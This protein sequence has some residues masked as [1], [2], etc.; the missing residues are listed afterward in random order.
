MAVV[1]NQNLAK[2]R[3]EILADLIDEM[4]G[5]VPDVYTGEEGNLMLLFQ[6][7]AGV[8]EAVNLAIQ[9]LSE[10]QFVYTANPVALERH[11][12]ERDIPLKV[13]TVSTGNLRISGAGGTY[14][15]LDSEAAYDPQTGDDLLYFRTTATGTIPN[16]GSPSA[17]TLADLVTAGNLTG[18]FEYVI[19]FL[20][21]EGET[22]MGAE[23]APLTVAASKIRLTNIPIGGAG[24]TKRRIYRQKNGSNLYQLVATINDNVLT[25]Y[26][27]NIADG[28]LGGQPPAISTAEAITLPVESV[29]AGD[30][31]NV[32]ANSITEVI[33]MPNGV[34]DTINLAAM[35]GGSDPED[36]EDFRAR[37]L[38][39]IQ[40]PNTGAPGDLKTWSE[41]ITGVETA[42]VFSND[43]FGT[44]TNGHTTVRIAGPNGAIPDISVQNAVAAALALK[45][46]ANIT[47]HVGTFTAVPTAVTVTI[48]VASGFVLADISAG[49]TQAITDYINSLQVGETIRVNGIIDAV[50]GLAGVADVAVS[51]PAT[52]LA[53]GATS[54]RTPGAITVS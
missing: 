4:Q 48:T 6:V 36:S 2:S 27:D 43:N 50:F 23:S 7:M 8:L 20:T 42:T 32:M 38:E 3:E 34:T 19:T 41:E 30:T 44:P 53:T 14:I 37:L 47:I 51:V 1:E 46:L 40:N 22:M 21:V 13:G 31:Y 16:P 24:T 52:N 45:D 9:I 35:T 18:T 17:S 39:A 11:G 28:A 54:K 15:D 25:T 26:D 12:I 10:D 49:I 33:D 29:E 5:L